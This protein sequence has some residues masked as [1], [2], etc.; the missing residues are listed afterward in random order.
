[1]ENNPFNFEVT[2][3]TTEPILMTF[4]EDGDA[5]DFSKDQNVKMLV[6]R[7][8]AD[9]LLFTNTGNADSLGNVTFSLTAAEL[10][11][12]G[13][14]DYQVQRLTQGGDLRVIREAEVRIKR[15][16]A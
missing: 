10:S 8:D 13:L 12:P 14:F 5:I 6:T 7:K 15:L 16:I 2:K 4:E 9:T 11:K 1:M 3:G